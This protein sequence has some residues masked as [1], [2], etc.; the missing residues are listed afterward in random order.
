M[1][2][3]QLS[4]NLFIYPNGHHE[5]AWRHPQS[6]PESSMDIGYYQQLALRA[7]REKLDAI[8]FADSPSLAESG[9]EGLRI[10]FEPVTWLAAIAAVTQRIGLIATASTTYSEPYNL[11]RSFSALDHLSKGRAGWNIVTTSMAAA[12]ANFGLDEHPSA[13]DRYAQAEEFVNVVGNLWDSW[14]DDALVLDKTAGVF[15]DSTKVHS[16]NH[17]G[18]YY[19]VK[20]PLNSPRSPQGRPVQVQAGSSEDGR[21]FAAR[22]AEAIFTAHQTLSSATEFANDIRARAKAVGR[23]PGQLKILPGISPYIASTEAEAQ[24]K[25]DELNDLVLPHVSLGQLRRMLGVDLSGQDLDAPFPRHLINFEGV[26]SQ[27]SRFKLIIDIVDREHVTLRQLINRLAGARGHWVPVGTPVQ[28]ADLIEQWFRSGAA[29]GFNVMPPAFPDGFDVFLDEVLPILRKR[30]L[31]RSEYAG[32]TLREHYGLT[33][34][35]SRYAL[36]TA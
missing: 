34:P 25:F 28:I 7:E 29:D 32:S 2:E 16:I 19:K 11:A 5:A 3:R 9:R 33:R 26:E 15:A 1:S 21:D 20:G 14:E 23:D 10:R 31:F 18:A 36:K 35:D 17:V 8:F 30:G 22:H 24:R 6:V 27:S 4:L 12:A 13:H